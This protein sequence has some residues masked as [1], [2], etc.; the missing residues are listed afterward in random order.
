MLLKDAWFQAETQTKSRAGTAKQLPQAR[1]KRSFNKKFREELIAY[2]PITRHGPRKKR[3]SQ[4][5]F[6]AVETELLPTNDSRI[7]R[8]RHT[9]QAIFLLLRV[10]VAAGTFLH[11]RC[12]ATIGGTH[13]LIGEICEVR[14]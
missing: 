13:R 1:I 5:F 11:S 3:R 10:F 8:S 9:C 14:R 12:L 6:V 4:Q 2:F 7:H